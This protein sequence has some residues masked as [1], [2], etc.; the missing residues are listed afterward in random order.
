MSFFISF[1]FFGLKSVFFHVSIAILLLH[2]FSFPSFHFQSDYVFGPKVSL[3][4]TACGWIMW[5]Y[6]FCQSVF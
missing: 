6:P 1:K 5:F 3:L 2:E 4:E